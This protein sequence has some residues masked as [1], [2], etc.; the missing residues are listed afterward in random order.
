MKIQNRI[1]ALVLGILIIVGVALV[2]GLGYMVWVN[3][4][5][6]N[7]AFIT[8]G[9]TMYDEN[10]IN[11][12]WKALVLNGV[13][14]DRETT[15]SA[16]Q[17]KLDE[18][19]KQNIATIQ[20]L[21]RLINKYAG[22]F[23]QDWYSSKS[24]IYTKFASAT[25]QDRILLTPSLNNYKTELTTDIITGLKDRGYLKNIDFETFDTYVL[26]LDARYVDLVAGFFDQAVDTN[27]PIYNPL[28]DS[29]IHE[30]SKSRGYTLKQA[31]DPKT[32]FTSTDGW[33]FK[34]GVYEKF[35]ELQSSAKQDGVSFELISAYRSESEQKVLF[36]EELQSYGLNLNQLS[37]EAYINNPATR[38]K[39]QN[40]L[41][42]VAPPGYSRHHTGV[43]FD[44]VSSEN[45][46]FG[47]TKAYQWLSADNYYNA[48]RFG[49]L[50]SYPKLEEIAQYGPN[51]EAWEYFYVGTDNTK[52]S[53]H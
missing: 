36:D 28:F 12:I 9:Q 27:K 44:L 5:Q 25:F 11:F 50:P 8:S 31:I 41:N 16:K 39:I 40:A 49:F 38:E 37:D 6:K 53:N 29:V 35:L 42:R 48:K 46:D 17:K 4:G 3:A 21:S 23:G 15:Y 45:R 18:I 13:I 19:S 10:E 26:V 33:V 14:P 32:L 20:Y 43:T 51:P 24:R 47:S 2:F 34:K 22:L 1:P 52:E 7:E 30:L